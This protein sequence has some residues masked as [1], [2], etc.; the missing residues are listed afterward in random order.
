MTSIHRS[1]SPATTDA[2]CSASSGARIRRSRL[3][4]W[5][6]SGQRSTPPVPNELVTYQGAPHS[7]F[8]KRYDEY[9]D[10]CGDAW[11]RILEFAGIN[12]NA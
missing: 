4:E 11:R 8:D 7:F 1:S 10:A 5:M 6:R 9:R 2:R 12:E 3:T